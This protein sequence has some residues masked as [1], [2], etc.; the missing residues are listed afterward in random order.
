MYSLYRDGDQFGIRQ[1]LQAPDFDLKRS[2]RPVGRRSKKPRGSFS[3]WKQYVEKGRV[4]G[5]EMDEEIL[6]SWRRCREMHVDPSPRS[7]WDFLPMSL[8]EPFTSTLDLVGDGAIAETYAAVKGGKLLITIADSNARLG[9]TY[10]DVEVLREADKLNFGPGA[11]WAENSVGTNA[12]GTALATGLPMQVFGEEHFCQSH[13]TW[14]CT[15][16][17][18]FDPHGN[19]WGCF[20]ISGPAGIDHS[21]C[22]GLVLQAARDIELQL[23]RFYFRELEI[24]LSSL[25]STMFNSVLTGM[26]AVDKSGR[27]RSVNSAAEALLGVP[28]QVLRGSIADAYFDMQA[29]NSD[30]AAKDRLQPVLLKCRTNPR[31]L[32]QAARICSATGSG[33]EVVLTI[34]EMQRA[35][36]VGGPQLGVQASARESKPK[37]FETILHNSP[38]MRRAIEQAVNA[39]KTPSTVLLVGETG[40]GKELFARGIHQAGKRAAGPFVAV[41]CGAFSDELVQSELFGYAPGA[42]TGAMRKGRIGK[43]EKAHKGVLFLDEISETPLSL[44]VNLLRALEDR[45][46]VPVG[47]L[48]PRSVDVKVI[49]ATNRDLEAM[50]AQGEFRRDLYYRI[51]VV[52]IEIPPLRK[53]PDDIALLARRRVRNLCEDFGLPLLEMDEEVFDILSAYDWP[54]NVRELFNCLEYAVNNAAG[55]KIGVGSLPAYLMKGHVAEEDGREQGGSQSFQ[56]E[57]READAIREALNFHGGNVSRTAKALG[58]GRTTLYAKMQKFHIEV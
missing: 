15:A 11:N 21:L 14:T 24:Q 41:N 36:G 31:L 3:Q 33:E 18:I 47:G 42:F 49:A 28:A 25:V 16:A 20:D 17:P 57:K 45:A 39:A 8:L 55:S 23:S 46:I 52:G 9:K 22:L 48:E 7:C 54:G 32:V 4:Q 1:E 50:V 34:C 38:V 13:H 37:G 29:L 51:N 2:S 5:D 26:A 12:I 6:A 43:F 58:I 10:G 35:R 56:L 40:S 19:L 27:I 30:Q 44:Q 53:R